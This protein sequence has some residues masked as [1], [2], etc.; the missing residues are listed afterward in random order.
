[1]DW[2]CD[3]L[4]LPSTAAIASSFDAGS[5]RLSLSG[6]A[7]LVAYQAALRTVTYRSTSLNPDRPANSRMCAL[8]VVDNS[9]NLYPVYSFRFGVTAVNS[10]PVVSAINNAYVSGGWTDFGGTDATVLAKW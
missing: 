7:S 6:V 1:M 8:A 4:A 10:A 5:G 9:G 2:L 3:V